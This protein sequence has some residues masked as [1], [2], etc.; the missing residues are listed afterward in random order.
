MRKIFLTFDRGIAQVERAVSV[1]ALV[2]LSS[3]LVAQIVFRYGFRQPIFWAEELAIALMTV[4][5]FSGLSL[6]VHSNRLVSLTPL[7][8][9]VSPQVANVIVLATQVIVII[10]SG[11]LAYY[12][13]RFVSSPYVWYE[14]SPTLPVPRAIYYVFF[15]VECAFMAVH[16]LAVILGG[17]SIIQATTPQG[18]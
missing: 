11:L 3:I 13:L 14:Q 10:L 9:Y 6:L 4:M 16:Q 12:A 7:T 1:F 17:R 18:A 2:S 8:N 15:G 5:A